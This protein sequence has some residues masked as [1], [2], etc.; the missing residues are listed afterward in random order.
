MLSPAPRCSCKRP[1]FGWTWS[2]ELV[3]QE[4]QRKLD[5][6]DDEIADQAE[7]DPS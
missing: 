5:A 4:K 3:G 1:F 6:F 2:V 7:N